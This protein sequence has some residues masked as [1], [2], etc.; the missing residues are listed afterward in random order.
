MKPKIYKQFFLKKSSDIKFYVITSSR[1]RGIPYGW[2]DGHDEAH[3]GIF[4]IF[5]NAPKNELLRSKGCDLGAKVLFR[6]TGIVNLEVR[7]DVSAVSRRKRRQPSHI[8][9]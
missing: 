5:P 4:A 9:H 7:G 2:T 3:L 8:D 1:S 6:V